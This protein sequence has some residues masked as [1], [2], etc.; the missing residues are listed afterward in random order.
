MSF[1]QLEFVAFLAAVLA[2]YWGLPSRRWQNLFLVCASAVFYGWIHPWFLLLLYGSAVLDFSLAQVI[3]YRPAWRWRCVAVSV[4][5]NLSVLAYFKYADFFVGNVV[6]ALSALGVP[7]D[8]TTLGILL[9]VGV[10]FYTFQTMGYTIDVARGELQAREDFVDY[11]LYVSFFTQLVAGPIERAG[12]LLPQIETDRAFSLEGLRAGVA[13]ALWGG[14]KK[15]VVADSLAP[16]VDKVFVLEQPA[17]PLIWAASFAFMIQIY[18]DFS[19]YTDIARGT[20]RMLGFE[21]TL[22]FREPFLAKTTVEFWQ[23]WHMSLSTWLRDYLLGPLVGEGGAGRVRFALATVATFVL[24]GFWHGPHWNFVVFGLF[25]GVLVVAY[26]VVPRLLPRGVR[27]LRGGSVLAVG[28]HLG[29]VG[30]VGSL[31]FRERRLDRLISHLTT[32]PWQGSLD[33]WAAT[34][35][36]LTVTGALCVPLLLQWVLVTR[37]APR[38][39]EPWLLPAQTTS[40]ALLVAAMFLFYRTTLQDFVYFQF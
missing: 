33:E 3:R 22:N 9:P 34:M 32:V 35:V 20:A 5:G 14:F 37:V 12:R 13:L 30:L 18:A 25:H 28:F 27:E 24:V 23:R 36:L 40:W 21:L 4:V 38:V 19:G 2:V 10:S 39:P 17:G 26:G 1:V 29:F 8:F 31:M 15:L 6:A 7:G 11:A 16:Y